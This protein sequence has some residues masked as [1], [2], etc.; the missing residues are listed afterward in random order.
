MKANIVFV[1]L[2]TIL[3]LGCGYGSNYNSKT[4]TMTNA[5]AI[6]SLSPNNAT[7]GAA[8]FTL[9]VTGSSFTS[10]SVIYW[11]NVS[12]TTTFVSATS[13]TTTIPASDLM[14]AGTIPVFVRTTTT[15]GGY[16]GGTSSQNSNTVNFTVM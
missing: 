13:L 5:P 11:N 14:N 2:L 8:Q 4:G 10:G 9:T 7:V 15:A 3:A 6:T 16:N 1:L 12:E